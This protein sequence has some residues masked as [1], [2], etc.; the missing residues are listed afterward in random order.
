MSSSMA[1]VPRQVIFVDTSF[2]VALAFPRDGRHPEAREL[3]EQHVGET[4][5][6]SNHVRGE[7]WT[8]LRRGAGHHTA[9][10]AFDPASTSCAR[11]PSDGHARL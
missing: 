1:R 10:R 8:V 3:D 5:L 7:T 9:S 6:T 4:L 2:W 11:K